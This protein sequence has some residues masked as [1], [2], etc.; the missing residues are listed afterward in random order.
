MINRCAALCS[1]RTFV[2]FF[3][4]LEKKNGRRIPFAKKDAIV[5]LEEKTGGIRD[6]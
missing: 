6:A 1:Q 2:V 4:F 3:P 5:Q